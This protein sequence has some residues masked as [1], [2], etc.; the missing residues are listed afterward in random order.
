[1]TVKTKKKTRKTMATGGNRKNG[2]QTADTNK[3]AE[4]LA[5][6]SPLAILFDGMDDAL[7][8]FGNQYT[9]PTLAVYSVSKILDVLQ[10]TMSYEDALDWFYFN[11]AC[12][13]A[14]SYTPIL[15]Y[16]DD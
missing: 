8:G 3:F 5:E 15:V 7:I 6:E 2:D 4:I 10:R 14:G 1:M 11:I 16:D 13:W 12:L 9:K